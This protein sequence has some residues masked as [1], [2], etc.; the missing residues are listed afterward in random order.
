[1]R[2]IILTLITAGLMLIACK[3]TNDNFE[4]SS[5][6]GKYSDKELLG[7][8]IMNYSSRDINNGITS[9]TDSIKFD[10]SNAG[11]RMIYQFSNLEEDIPFLYYTEKDNL[12]FY[13]G[14]IKEKWVYTIRNDSLFL[15]IPFPAY[16][17]LNVTRFYKK[18]E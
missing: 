11:N 10:D 18:I 7:V 4:G 14:Q 8:W 6:I 1:M 2:K 15:T 17:S 16:S 5:I 3:K 12:F 13:I 9:W